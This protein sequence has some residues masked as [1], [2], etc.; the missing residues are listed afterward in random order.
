MKYSGFTL[1]EL[2]VVLVIIGLLVGAILTGQDLMDAAAQRAQVTQIGKYN[3]AVYAFKNKYGYL[4]G[5]IP[6]PTASQFGFQARGTSGGQGDGNGRIE[7]YG[8]GSDSTDCGY[9]EGAG[10]TSVFWVD[11]ST[12]GLIDGGFNTASS[13][14]YFSGNIT[15]TSNPSLSAYF[16]AAK[17]G[18]G[19]YIY[20]WSGGW[21]DS[22]HGNCDSGDGNN[23]FG[24]SPISS[25][26]NGGWPSTAA[27]SLSASQA[28]NIDKKIDDGLP[29]SGNVMAVY[30]NFYTPFFG[31]IA[32]AAGGGNFGASTASAAPT[33]AATPYAS[34]NCYD[35]NNIAGTQQT[36]SLAQN[37]NAPNCALSFKFQ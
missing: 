2:S 22:G 27:T 12:A 19:N 37:A 21:A 28:Y 17:L 33:T 15:A 4:P 25:L 34:T 3:T 11:L 7:G 9:Y 23:Y 8:S 31:D 29:Q 1:I 16:P 30:L 18:N 26:L 13:H 14:T 32:W 24:L 20:V 36:Y 35:N 5:D 10:E 6:D